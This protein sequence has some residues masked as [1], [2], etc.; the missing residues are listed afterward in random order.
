MGYK[1]ISLDNDGHCIAV[2]KAN[3]MTLEELKELYY[4]EL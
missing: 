3:N 4:I 1:V 2:D